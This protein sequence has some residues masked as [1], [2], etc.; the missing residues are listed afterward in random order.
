MYATERDV[1]WKLVMRS[2]YRDREGGQC[3]KVVQQRYGA[4]Y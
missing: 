2:K 4:G 1:L 3:S